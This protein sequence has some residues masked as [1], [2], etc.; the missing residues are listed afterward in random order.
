MNRSSRTVALWTLIVCTDVARAQPVAANNQKPSFTMSIGLAEKTVKIGSE[1]W[2]IVDL[3]NTSSGKI[4]LWQPRT[5]APVY[6]V[7]VVNQGG[8]AVPMTA[9]GRA[10]RKRDQTY[11]PK[12][13]GP[14]RTLGANTGSS[15][16]IEPGETVKDKV[17]VQDQVDL[18][19]PGEYQ[20]RLER[21]D[22]MTQ[23]PVRSNAV[24]LVVVK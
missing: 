3:T 17:T 12:E 7:D 5:G 21:V 23:I 1:V 8:R 16:T 4:R 14:V 2:V 11:A 13:G 18:S 15:V 24:T 10:L 22:P 9:L 19:A 6:T 20:I